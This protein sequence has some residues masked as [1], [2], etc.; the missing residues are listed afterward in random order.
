GCE[1]PDVNLDLGFVRGIPE[2]GTPGYSVP[3]GKWK[4]LHSTRDFSATSGYRGGLHVQRHRF[5]R[6]AEPSCRGAGQGRTRSDPSRAGLLAGALSRPRR[7][8]RFAAVPDRTH[9]LSTW[10]RLI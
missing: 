3:A 9:E 6:A 7:D 10:W 4:L 5:E 2:D 1:V 8:A